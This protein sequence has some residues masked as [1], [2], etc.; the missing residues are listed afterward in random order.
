MK[1]QFKQE[2][3][4]PVI[5]TKRDNCFTYALKRLTGKGTELNLFEY[6]ELFNSTK[7]CE[8]KLKVG[9]VVLWNRYAYY[10]TIPGFID[11]EGN[12]KSISVPFNRHC[13][14]V[15][16]LDPIV[17]SECLLHS[18]KYNTQH[19]LLSELTKHKRIPDK[20]LTLKKLNSK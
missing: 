16:S 1:N 15:E 8:K 6:K 5:I 10:K 12:V 17:I 2:E 18:E 7:F 3:L 13:A 20:I 19:I 14:V 4:F 9:S 11:T